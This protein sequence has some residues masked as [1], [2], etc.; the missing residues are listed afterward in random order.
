MNSFLLHFYSLFAIKGSG[1]TFIASALA[2]ECNLNLISVKGPELLSKYIG[3]SESSVRDLFARA[4]TAAPSLIFLDELDSLCP[5]RGGD[6]TGVTDRIVNQF[7][8]EL[9]GVETG[10]SEATISYGAVEKNNKDEID[11]AKLVFILG[12]TSRPDMIDAALLRPGR[13]DKLLYC[14]L[15]DLNARREILMVSV[16]KLFSTV[17]EQAIGLTQEIQDLIGTISRNTEGFS[18]ADLQ[19]IVT[20]AQ[21]LRV[22]DAIESLNNTKLSISS[23]QDSSSVTVEPTLPPLTSSMLWK[24]YQQS[25][26][27]LSTADATM[28]SSIYSRFLLNKEGKLGVTFDPNVKQRTAQ[29]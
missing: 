23:I 1:K 12:A 22:H 15:P 11:R 10:S 16:R 19:S 20:N 13:L 25:S 5:K 6:T 14:P 17:D 29:A 9:D 28:Y 26:A 24:A 27:S 2:N 7:L 21:L 8:C 4:R 18:G 3:S